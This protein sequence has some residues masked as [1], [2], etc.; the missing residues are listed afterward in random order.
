MTTSKLQVQ[1]FLREFKLAAGKGTGISYTGRDKNWD[2]LANLNMTSKMRNDCVLGL[3]WKD[4]C[5]GPLEDDKGRPGEVWMFG[6][7]ICGSEVYIKLKLVRGSHPVCIS[8]HN[9]DL[10]LEYPFRS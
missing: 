7:D 5:R 8:F 2:T 4:Y 3:T 1:L 9:A 10:P 6:T